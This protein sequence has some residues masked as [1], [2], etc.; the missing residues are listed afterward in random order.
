[1]DHHTWFPNPIVADHMY[2]KEDLAAMWNAIDWPYVRESVFRQQCRIVRA[3]L[4][5]N[6]EEVPALQ[7]EL[8]DMDDAKALAVWEVMHRKSRDTPGVDGVVWETPAQWM[9]AALHLNTGTYESLPL[10]RFYIPKE[11]GKLRPLGI[12]AVQDRAMQ[13]LYNFALQPVAE[14]WGDPGSFGYRLYRSAKDAC[15][16]IRVFLSREPEDE[17]WVLDGDIT[18]CFDNIRH[19]WLLEHIPVSRTFLRQVLKSGYIFGRTYFPTK[20]GV[21]Q[22]GIISPVLANMALDGL[23][24]RLMKA[25][26]RQD[27]PGGTGPGLRFVRYADDFVVLTV[28][29][30]VAEEAWDEVNAFLRPRGLALSEEKTRIVTVREGFSFL[31]WRFQN[32]SAGLSVRPSDGSVHHIRQTI[33]E[34]FDSRE[35]QTPDELILKLNPLLRGYAYYHRDVE[36]GELFRSLDECIRTKILGQ[37]A[38]WFPGEKPET[39]EKRFFAHPD[40]GPPQFRTK[41]GSLYLLSSTPAGTHEM[42]RTDL[43]AFLDRDILVRREEQGD[44]LDRA[45]YEERKKS[46]EEGRKYG[47]PEYW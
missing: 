26:G 8:V 9:S 5:G 19:D 18:G 34:F 10:L 36:A 17:V 32:Q 31:H 29:R 46:R 12:S 14:T 43:N 45:V 20:R 35:F 2:S 30:S 33:G 16:A 38:G 15:S 25:F 1:M 22:G 6:S 21:P 24:P 4:A 23:E 44:S 42:P 11:S 27:S 13:M 47:T 40:A 39:R 28:S 37:L 41:T 3:A 7:E